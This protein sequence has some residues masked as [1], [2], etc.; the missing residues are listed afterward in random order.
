MVLDFGSNQKQWPDEMK[1]GVPRALY[2][3]LEFVKFACHN[4]WNLPPVSVKVRGH[5]AHQDFADAVRKIPPRTRRR[6]KY[7]RDFVA[8][9]TEQIY[10][11]AAYAPTLLD[12]QKVGIISVDHSTRGRGTLICLTRSSGPSQQIHVSELRSAMLHNPATIDSSEKLWLPEEM[13]E[14]VSSDYEAAGRGLVA[15]KNDNRS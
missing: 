9:G 6:I 5:D 8:P 15:W 12:K 2:Q 4:I 11:R 14:Y 1:P 10:L 13:I 7:F 3:G